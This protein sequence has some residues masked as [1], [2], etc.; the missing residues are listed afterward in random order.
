MAVPR[1]SRNRLE[2]SE[3]AG[4][5]GDWFTYG[6]KLLSYGHRYHLAIGPHGP[7]FALSKVWRYGAAVLLPR[8]WHRSHHSRGSSSRGQRKILRQ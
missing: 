2:N 1:H 6:K 7:G 8:Q 3:D 4:F 5:L